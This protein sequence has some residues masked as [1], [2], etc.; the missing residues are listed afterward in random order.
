MKENEFYTLTGY[1]K[2]EKNILTAGMEDYL[3]MCYRIY[4]EKKTIHIKDL[5][6]NL[7]VK[8]SSSTKM[9][10]RIKD[11]GLVTF[12]KYGNIEL[13]EDGMIYGKYL[14]YRHNV[15]VNFFQFLNKEDYKL[16]QVEKIEHFIDTTSIQ[17]IEKLLKNK[18]Y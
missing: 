8:A 6:F 13:T 4:Q 18:L 16:E 15:L 9:M 12:E 5:S 14:L 11:L 3:E 2:K 10:N 1:T 7:H 17:N